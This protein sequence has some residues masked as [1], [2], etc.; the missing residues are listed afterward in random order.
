M[1]GGAAIL[2]YHSQNVSGHSTGN[3]DHVA[4]AADI[5]RVHAGGFEMVSLAALLARLEAGN[6]LERLVC[7]TFDDGCDFDVR[8]LDF[9]GHGMQRSF[10]GILEDFVARHGPEAQP[11]LHAT[12]FVIASPKAREIID[13]KSLFGNGWISDDWWQDAEASPLMSIGNHGW[14]HNHPDLF[15]DGAGGGFSDI[16]APEQCLEQVVRSAS[17]IQEK[18]GRWPEW[19]AY[20]FGESSRYI[21]ESFFPEQR[22][23]HRCRAAL[24]TDPGHVTRSSDLW[25]LPRYVCGRDWKAPEELAALLA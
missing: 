24:G 4:L 9:P 22:P 14:D 20:P 21:R 15:P 19:F 5:D 16:E 18:T 2:T 25:N 23:V 13:R 11:G 17:F 12:S 3:N 7:L 6:P 10:L 8:D 1:S